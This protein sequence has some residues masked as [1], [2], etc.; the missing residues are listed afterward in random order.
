M[1]IEQHTQNTKRRSYKALFVIVPVILLAIAGG[2]YFGLNYAKQKRQPVQ[3]FSY[4]SH[5]EEA[6]R[7]IEE[8]L[9]K[10]GGIKKC[11]IGSNGG[12]NTEGH[13]TNY[14]AFFEVPMSRDKAVELI[15]NIAR[16]NGFTLTHA[17]D[18]RGPVPVA[19][20]Y[21][22]DWYYDTTSKI[23]PYS[24]LGTGYIYLFL[25]VN[26]DGKKSLACGNG[27]QSAT[28]NTGE[29]VTMVG[30]RLGLPK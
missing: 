19:D 15:K 13:A 10:A 18:K 25:T 7:P 11:T 26:N 6:A 12:F 21:L 8:G 1:Q 17:I 5:N 4:A 9:T 28:F 22:D 29:H 23:N 30:I 3:S 2:G 27:L 16:N 24:D 14:N 20:V